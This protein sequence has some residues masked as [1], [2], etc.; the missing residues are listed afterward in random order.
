MPLPPDPDPALAAYAHPE[1]LVT[2]DWLSGNLGRPGPGHRRVRRGRAALRH[3]PHSR[4][5]EDRLAHRPQ[6]PARPRLHQRRA[7]RRPDEPQ[8][9]LPR[10]HRGDLRRQEQLVGGLR[11]VG[12]HPVRP[13]RRPPA[14]RR[15]RPVDLRRP[16]HHARRAEQADQRLP[17]RRA[18]RRADPGVQG[19]RARRPRPAAADRRP[20][21]AGVHR[22]TH[23]HAGL[24]RGRRAARR[25]HPDRALDPVGQGRPGQR[26]VPQPRRAR[27][28]VRI[29]DA[30]TT[31]P[32]STAA[33]ASGPATPGSC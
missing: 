5:G 10:R 12:V 9:H 21:A 2:A 3:R 11:A 6:R 15:P 23:P 31:R 32:S 17:R 19:R 18:R 4:R 22:R 27:R 24:P 29:P 8:G 25:P 16:R 13:P 28:A 20:L 7:V 30:A 26:P 1:R 14:R 33:S